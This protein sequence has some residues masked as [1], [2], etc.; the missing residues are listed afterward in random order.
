MRRG[1]NLLFVAKGLFYF[2]T[3]IKA[4]NTVNTSFFV[5]FVLS[6]CDIRVDRDCI[7]IYESGLN[8]NGLSLSFK[9]EFRFIS[10]LAKSL[11]GW[12]TL[13]ICHSCVC[14]SCVSSARVTRYEASQPFSL[15]YTSSWQSVGQ[16][17]TIHPRCLRALPRSLL[18]CCCWFAEHLR[19]SPNQLK[20]EHLEEA[21]AIERLHPPR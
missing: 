18:D 8:N 6:W 1:R 16:V 21:P 7:Y 14:S 9:S 20:S 13:P 11:D 15:T 3:Y 4:W 2:L 19:R 5:V 17:H 10:F 12:P